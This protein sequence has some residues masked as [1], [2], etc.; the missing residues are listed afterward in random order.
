MEGLP[1]RKQRREW[2][3]QAG[4]L[5]KKKNSSLKDKMEMNSRSI[6]YGK[7]IHLANIERILREE[8]DKHNETIANAAE[9]LIKEGYTQEEAMEKIK[10][11]KI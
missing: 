9:E 10:F 5:K 6:E 7:Q 3:K 2:A 8:D 4:M 11:D 1:N